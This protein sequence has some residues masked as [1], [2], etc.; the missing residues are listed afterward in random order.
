MTDALLEP[1]VG[2]GSRDPGTSGGWAIDH[3]VPAKFLGLFSP[4]AMTMGTNNFGPPPEGALSRCF[5]VSGGEATTT[6]GSEWFGLANVLKDA[7][8]RIDFLASRDFDEDYAKPSEEAR[9]RARDALSQVAMLTMLS[10]GGFEEIFDSLFVTVNGVG[11]YQ[12]EFPVNDRY[13]ELLVGAG[14]PITVVGSIGSFG[15][16]APFRSAADAALVATGFLRAEVIGRA[17]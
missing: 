10:P 12:L 8:D 7:F 13:V 17:G 4:V 14:G 2:F 6:L 16:D 3:P 1:S 9:L 5:H 11:E 15:I